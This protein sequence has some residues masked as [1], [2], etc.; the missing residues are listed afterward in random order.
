MNIPR[1]LLS[2]H[3]H[4]RDWPGTVA[5]RFISIKDRKVTDLGSVLVASIIANRQT[6]LRVEEHY[7]L[8]DAAESYHSRNSP[9]YK[10]LSR[11]RGGKV[12]EGPELLLYIHG[13]DMLVTYL[14]THKSAQD[15][16]SRFKSINGH[17]RYVTTLKVEEAGHK[18]KEWFVPRFLISEF[19]LPLFHTEIGEFT[20]PDNLLAPM[21]EAIDNA[22]AQLGRFGMA[23]NRRAFEDLIQQ[24][25]DGDYECD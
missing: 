1:L 15:N 8:G 23:I 5:G 7:S 6:I 2:Q 24:A 25:N 3:G 22:V 4:Q 11:L 13:H 21:S 9:G 14:L 18:R 19:A 16:F 10:R 20:R 12:Y 17:S